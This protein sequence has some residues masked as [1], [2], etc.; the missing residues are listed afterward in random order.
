MGQSISLCI[1]PF[2]I[3]SI[4]SFI[5][6]CQWI[7]RKVSDHGLLFN[8]GTGS[9]YLF[10]SKRKEEEMDSYLFSLLYVLGI[11]SCL[12]HSLR[13]STGHCTSSLR[14]LQGHVSG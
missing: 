14:L 6:H 4:V 3:E 7:T 5:F 2:V 11:R 10:R 9:F 13:Y 8:N 12:F 1:N